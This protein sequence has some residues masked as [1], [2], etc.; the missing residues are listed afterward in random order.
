MSAVVREVG[1]RK[2]RHHQPRAMSQSQQ[3]YSLNRWLA[4]VAA[5]MRPGVD[6]TWM[7][8]LIPSCFCARLADR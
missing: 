6:D 4:V 1:V 5:D 8:L 3:K 2:I 7:S